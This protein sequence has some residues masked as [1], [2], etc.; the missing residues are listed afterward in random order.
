MTTP[1]TSTTDTSEVGNPLP[2]SAS[3]SLNAI[4]RANLLKLAGTLSL[5]LLE[6]ILLV[7]YPLF[8]GFAINAIIKGLWLQASTYA[9][10]VLLFWLIGALRRAVDTRT[11]TRIY[12]SLAVPVILA[13]RQQQES[14]STIVARVALAREFV[15]F[16]E[17]HVPIL[18]TSLISIVGAALMLTLIEFWVGVASLGILLLFAI[19]LPRFSRKNQM[20]HERLNDRLE[21]EV[22]LVTHAQS[23][24]LSRHYNILAWLRIQISD[25]E[26]FAFLVVG[27]SAALLFLLAI[28]M[29]V[30]QPQVSAGHV[31]AVMTYLWNF[32]TSLDEG[33]GL[34]DQL[35]RL[36]DIGRRVSTVKV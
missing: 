31:Y 19:L 13:Q 35:A 27:I 23:V 16:F 21:H 3:R 7:V 20:L 15:D 33:P 26:A 9:L 5:V 25:R 4:A 1:S 18:A 30:S 2:H 22:K 17:K 8:A 34:A 14:Q 6:N 11:F 24:S 32:V 10:I 28:T 36:R 29:L 12:A